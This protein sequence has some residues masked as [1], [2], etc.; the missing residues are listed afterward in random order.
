[1][2]DAIKEIN[3]ESA[4]QLLKKLE[5]TNE[6]WNGTRQFWVFRGHGDD[7]N[8]ELVPTALRRSNPLPELGYTFKPKKGP[9]DTNQDQIDAEFER[10]HEFF[11]AIDAQGLGVPGD[12]NLMRTPTNWE[13]LKGKINKQDGWPADALLPLLALAQHYGVA[14]RLLD[15]SDKPLVAA[16]FAAAEAAKLKT[17]KTLSVWALN[18]DWIINIAFPAFPTNR[19]EEPKNSKISVF[20]VTAPRC[21]NPNL[22]AQGGVFTTEKLVSCEL[23][24]KLT[25][26]SVNDIVKKEWSNHKCDKPVMAHITLPS[27]K[28]GELLRLLNQEGINSATLLPGYKGVADSLLERNLW[29][30]T[31]ITSYWLKA[32]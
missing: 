20:V 14:T 6:L 16:Y 26:H 31:E 1:M 32:K 2:C 5:R 7:D 22:H 11:W 21:S 24:D 29:D 10:I 9:F 13:E 19:P 30:K 8:Y 18:L 3:C 12:I 17:G 25:V 15:W 27:Q 4:D 28:A 23:N